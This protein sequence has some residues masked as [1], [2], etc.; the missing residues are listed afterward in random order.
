MNYTCH[1]KKRN[2]RQHLSVSFVVVLFALLIPGC[3]KFLDVPPKDNVPQSTLFKDEQGFKDALLGVYLGM[4][5]PGRGSSNLGLY[6]NKLS[7]GMVSTLAYQYDNANVAN[8]GSNG[9]FYN[10]VVYYNYLDGEVRRE[11]DGIWGDV[12]NNIAD[13]NNILQEID[14]KKDVFTRDNYNRVKGEAIALRALFHFDLARMFGK[15]PVAGMQTNAIPY[16]TRFGVTSTRFIPLQSVLDSCITDLTIAKDLLASTDTS[17]ILKADDDLFSA[18][19]QNHINY[20]AVQGLLARVYLYKGDIENADKYARAVIGSNKFPL[21]TSNVAAKAN[22]IRDR[23]FAQEHLFSVYSTNITKYNTDLFD[24]TSG[25]PLRFSPAGRRALYTTGSGNGS[26][27]RYTSWFDNSRLSVTD[28]IPSKFFQDNNLPYE[29]QNN[30]PV[31]R[32]SEMYYI[33]AECAN[34][35]NDIAGGASLLNKVRQ[36][37]GLNA[38]NPSGIS[39]TDSL[40]TEIMREYQKE[41]IQEGQTWFYYKRLNKDLKQTISTPAMIPADVY[42]FPIPDKEKEYNY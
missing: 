31:I 15:S 39:S 23:T 33:A 29:L 22:I 24:K 19:T 18:Y 34:K 9:A 30:M 12:Y 25:V 8:A 36:A 27:Y 14:G 26:D 32:V 42:V 20:W 1:N 4:D 40:T 7:M 13:L 16:I 38:L 17:V 35:K 3:S 5:K 28:T 10:N 21:I 6:T 37:R 41:F 2:N 11:I